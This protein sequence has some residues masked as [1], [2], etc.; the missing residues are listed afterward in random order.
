MGTASGKTS[1]GLRTATITSREAYGPEACKPALVYGLKDTLGQAALVA[2]LKR[3]LGILHDKQAGFIKQM[4]AGLRLS[5]MLKKSKYTP[6]FFNYTNDDSYKE[7]SQFIAFVLCLYLGIIGI[8]RFYLGYNIQGFFMIYTYGGALI[9]WFID[10][11]RIVSGDL[12]PNKGIYYD[13]L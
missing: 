11:I 8:H 1:P 3:E 13:L 12:K 10:L 2:S 4:R 7:R 9:W 6:P 5:S